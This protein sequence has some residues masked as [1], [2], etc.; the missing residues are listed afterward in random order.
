MFG[1]GRQGMGRGFRFY[2]GWQ[3]NAE[4]YSYLGPCRCGFGPHAFWQEKATGR[5][6][7]GFPGWQKAPWPYVSP[8][9]ADLQTEL[10]LL[11]Q[12]KKDLE[13]RIRDLEEELK[14]AQDKD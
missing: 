13:I 9:E 8:K 11:K 7:R 10:D 12:E 14:K 2:P 6:F 1:Y 5:I 4:G 3:T